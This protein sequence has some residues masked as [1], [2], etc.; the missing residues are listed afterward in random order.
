VLAGRAAFIAGCTGTSNAEAG[1]R[2]GIPVFGT[3]AHSWTM[4]FPDEESSFRSLQN[5][6]GEFTVFLIDT[7]D[8]LEG[9]RLAAKLGKPLWGVRL[10]S[11]D[12]NRLSRQ[13]RQILDSAGL[14]E[15]KIMAT[16]DLN[17]DRLAELVRAGAPIDTFGVGTELATSADSPTLSAV[18]KLVE[19]KRENTTHY[20]AKFSDDKETLPAAKQIY[21]GPDGDL[22]ANYDECNSELKG[23]VLLRPI[24]MRGKLLEPL[25]STEQIQ[26]YA[27]SAIERLPEEVLSLTNEVRYPVDVSPRILKLAETLRGAYQ[28]VRS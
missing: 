2:F 13:V 17:E 14:Q 19:I 23:D 9:A 22:L 6:L 15:A 11:G 12:L 8:T 10:D 25:P 7:Y 16:N 3:A 1:R 20:A 5:L 28:P 26:A 4:A 21:R 18:Y 27:T 24:V